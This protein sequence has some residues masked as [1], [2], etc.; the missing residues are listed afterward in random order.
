MQKE[1]KTRHDWVGKVIISELSKKLKTNPTI[2]KYINKPESALENK[3]HQILCNFEI[4]TDLQIPPRRP[5]RMILKKKEFDFAVQANHRVSIKE[6]QKRDKY[7]DL[8]K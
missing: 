5:D 6:T 2:K 4:Q 8:A 3:M 1:F 7:L